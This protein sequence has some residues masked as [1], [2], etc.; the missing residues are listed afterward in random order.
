MLFGKMYNISCFQLTVIQASGVLKKLECLGLTGEKGE[1]IVNHCLL[2]ARYY[3]FSCKHKDSKSSKL[4]CIYQIKSNLK[5]EKQISITTKTQKDFKQ[6]WD[7]I[8][9]SLLFERLVL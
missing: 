6:K 3:I 5:I 8:L 2:L 1:I 9:Q 4:E 7:K